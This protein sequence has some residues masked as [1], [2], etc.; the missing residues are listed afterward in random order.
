MIIYYIAI[1]KSKRLR[2]MIS[3]A[4]GLSFVSLYVSLCVEFS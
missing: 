2:R 3:Y 1:P 4:A